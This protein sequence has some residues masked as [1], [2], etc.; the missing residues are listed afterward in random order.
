MK[1]ILLIVLWSSISAFGEDNKMRSIVEPVLKRNFDDAYE[2]ARLLSENDKIIYEDSHGNERSESKGLIIKL[3]KE[4]EREDK[5]CR[6]LLSQESVGE[7][8]TD[9]KKCHSFLPKDDDGTESEMRTLCAGNRDKI[10]AVQKCG[11]SGD[12]GNLLKTL[13]SYSDLDYNDFIQAYETK[14]KELNA[15]QQA[16]IEQAKKESR[17]ATRL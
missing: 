7:M 14:I 9:I 12:L 16:L 2:R 3:I 8:V 5:K 11:E 4:I 15:L 13:K 17:R 10:G 1:A 6:R